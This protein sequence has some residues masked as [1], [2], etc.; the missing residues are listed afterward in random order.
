MGIENL[1]WRCSCGESRPPTNSDFMSLLRGL[2]HRGHK[3]SLVNKETG[4]ELAKTPKE[5]MSKGIALPK[6]GESFKGQPVLTSDGMIDYTLTLPP[7]ALALFNMAKSFGLIK[8]DAIGFDE[9]VFECIDRRFS[10][11]YGVE[12][13]LQPIGAKRDTKDIVREV[14]KE[15]LAEGKGEKGS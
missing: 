5:A 7:E 2:E 10:C 11:D 8:D 1:E 15:V 12:I 9:W 14:V 13:V 4:E 6:K 3:I